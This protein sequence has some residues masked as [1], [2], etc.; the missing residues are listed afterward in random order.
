MYKTIC[1]FILGVLICAPANAG[2]WFGGDFVDQFGDTIP[3]TYISYTAGTC[4]MVV[5]KDERII[6]FP[7][8]HRITGGRFLMKNSEGSILRADIHSRSKGFRLGG[9]ESQA[10]IDFLNDSNGVIRVLIIDKFNKKYRF[11]IDTHSFTDS[12]DWLNR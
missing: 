1:I 11:K 10:V 6:I 8:R 3:K 2:H 4:K 12:W 5:S 9:Y 7:G